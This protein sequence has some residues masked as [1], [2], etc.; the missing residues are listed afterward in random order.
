MGRITELGLTLDAISFHL[1]KKAPRYLPQ[2]LDR[3][4]GPLLN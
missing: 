3:A 1:G 2:L 4:M